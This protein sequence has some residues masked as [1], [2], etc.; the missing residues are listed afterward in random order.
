MRITH[1]EIEVLQLIVQEYTSKEISAK[2]Y[3]STE[4]VISHRK[5]LVQKLNAKNTAGLVS[6][7]YRGGILSA[8]YF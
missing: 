1:R 5:N 6:K 8:P 7:A 2:L 4:T 3:V